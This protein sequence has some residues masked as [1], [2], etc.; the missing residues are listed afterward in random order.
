M[1]PY[2]DWLK[3]YERVTA[4]Y[5]DERLADMYRA[6]RASERTVKRGI[7][8]LKK[9]GVE[10]GVL[11]KVV[12]SHF[13]SPRFCILGDVG[14]V[15]TNRIREYTRELIGNTYTVD[16]IAPNGN[17]YLNVGGTTYPV[18][19]RDIRKASIKT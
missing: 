4:G 12:G 16:S 15:E 17:V 1:L 13:L 9:M 11:V 19:L 18:T 8:K 14:N 5:T 6:Q 7:K 2:K 10:A 3:R